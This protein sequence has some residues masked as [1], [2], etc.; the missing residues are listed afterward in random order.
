MTHHPE[1]EWVV[2]LGAD[3]AVV[4]ASIR[5]EPYLPQGSKVR[6][7]THPPQVHLAF[8]P[9]EVCRHK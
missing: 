6:K 1:V 8:C 4:N 5:L 9:E 3:T 2:M 7:Q